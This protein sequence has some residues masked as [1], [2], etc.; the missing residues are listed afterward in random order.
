MKYWH[1]YLPLLENKRNMAQPFMKFFP[2]DYIADTRTLSTHT[3]GCYMDLLCLLHDYDG[4][5]VKKVSALSKLFGCTVKQAV[6]AIKELEEEGIIEVEPLKDN[7][8]HLVSRRMKRD[9]ENKE[10]ER[11][12][13]REYRT[14]NNDSPGD[15]PK[16]VP[17]L[18]QKCPEENTSKNSENV[19]A[20]SHTHQKP[21]NQ[22]PNSTPKSP[23]GGGQVRPA[24]IRKDSDTL[25]ESSAGGT[26][27][28]VLSEN[29]VE[30]KD[31][32]A[33]CNRKKIKGIS[34]EQIKALSD[35][36]LAHLLAASRE[37]LSGA[38]IRNPLAVA[39]KRA[40]NNIDQPTLEDRRT[41]TAW[42]HPPPPI[43]DKAINPNLPLTKTHRCHCGGKLKSEY[44]GGSGKTTYICQTCNRGYPKR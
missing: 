38:D 14:K 17:D 9:L 34:Y 40:E 43:K 41:I 35:D 3:K 15:V 37:K 16:E 39:K 1:N 26:E 11:D 4:E 13:K 44:S 20:E 42:L 30:K 28:N 10:Y 21:E 22:K 7:Q 31:W 8:Y 6:R 33:L 19:P 27:G 18:S 25:R 32:E 36:T 24:T 12:R 29:I 5:A 23:Q 2:T